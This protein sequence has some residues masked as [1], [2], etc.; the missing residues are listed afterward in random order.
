MLKRTFAKGKGLS[1]FIT[2]T[3]IFHFNLLLFSSVPVMKAF[4][5]VFYT[6]NSILPSKFLDAELYEKHVPYS[7]LEFFTDNG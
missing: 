5:S 6:N 1:V 2:L 7:H 3:I 4:P